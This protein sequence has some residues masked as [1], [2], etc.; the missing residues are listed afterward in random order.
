MKIRLSLRFQAAVLLVGAVGIISAVF[1]VLRS[2]GESIDQV[3]ASMIRIQ[4]FDDHNHDVFAGMV[5]EETGLRGYVLTGDVAFLQAYEF[6]QRQVATAEAA[7]SRNTPEGTA[8]VVVAEKA[9][10]AS[11]QQWAAGRMALF[12]IAGP[13]VSAT[14]TEGK[15]LF[16]DFRSGWIAVNANDASLI[17]TAQATLARH[18][19]SASTTRNLGWLAI[20]GGLAA[21]ATVIFL[22]ILR[23]LGQQSRAALALDGEKIVE[24]PGR[25]RKDEIGRLASTLEALQA[26]LRDRVSLTRAMEEIGGRAE[27]G[28]VVDL[29]TRFFAAQLDADE[30]LIT[31]FD[32]TSR[33]VAGTHAG[34]I[35]PGYVINQLTPSDQALATR[36]TVISSVDQMPPGEI[37]DLAEAH[38]YGPLLTLPMF[39]GGEIVGTIIGVRASWRPQFGAEEVQRAEILA[40]VIGAAAKVARLVGEIRDA[41]QVKSRFLANM[42]HELRTPLNAILGF[43]QVLSAADF[44]PLN[45]RQQRYVGHIES[46]GIRL[47]E[48]INDIL[49]LSKVEAGLLE[50][51]PERL[52]LAQLMISCHSEIERIA[53]NKGVDL[54]YNLTPGIWAWAEPRRLQQV[55]LNLLTNAVKFTPVGG[56]VTLSTAMVD[57]HVRAI[58]SDTGIGIAPEEHDRIFDEFV[59]ADDDTAREEK[60]TGL[61]L[62]LSRKLTELMGGTLT[63][64]SEIGKGSRFTIELSLSDHSLGTREGPLALVVEAAGASTK[65]VEALPGPASHRVAVDGAAPDPDPD[66]VANA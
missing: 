42:S 66:R 2:G 26:T 34:L 9:A 44:G 29:G 14:D 12:A 5:N 22:R 46:S 11:W 13:G 27:L 33:Y 51:R 65:S 40:P 25:G 7:L 48:L 57:G 52:D 37:R 17:D 50:L 6:G 16:D 63:V 30:A 59:Q 38:D 20:I 3:T 47:L 21:L 41:N 55:V 18:L 1:V 4:G 15:R 56:R 35:P 49:D 23:P 28:D 36:K 62:S 53:A 54:V 32:G 10:A 43:S 24:I 58:V 19:S 39:T 61:G 60:G 45:E 8:T 31:L 64:S